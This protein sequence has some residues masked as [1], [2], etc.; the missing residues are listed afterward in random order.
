MKDVPQRAARRVQKVSWLSSV[1]SPLRAGLTAT[2]RYWPASPTSTSSGC[3]QVS[4]LTTYACVSECVC[5]CEQCVYVCACVCMCVCV[6]VC[7]R[8]CVRVY[9]RK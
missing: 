1:Y 8:V 4:T 3:W 2:H 5:V 7:A 9:V 6:C